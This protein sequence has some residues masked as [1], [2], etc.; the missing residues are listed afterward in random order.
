M[1]KIPNDASGAMCVKCAVGGTVWTGLVLVHVSLGRGTS[2][3]VKGLSR[4]CTGVV[5]E[6]C[7]KYVC[8]RYNGR[9]GG[10]GIV[11]V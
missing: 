5:I 4:V 11:F 3:R 8:L 1:G 7:G 10:F 2:V 9:D 6:A